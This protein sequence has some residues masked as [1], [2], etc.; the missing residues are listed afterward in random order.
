MSDAELDHLLARVIAEMRLDREGER[1][2]VDELRGHLDEAIADELARGAAPQEALNRAAARFGLG[3]LVGRELQATHAGWGT[4][5]AVVAA[6][7]PVLCGLVLRWLVYAPD[8]TAVGWPQL[9][10][11]PTFWVVALAALV[12]PLVQFPRWRYALVS[13]GIFWVMTVIFVTGSA[14]QW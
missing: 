6:A 10:E 14:V 1:E 2:V 5:D 4:A 12:I 9:L 3:D 11:R 13:W 7:M 8:G